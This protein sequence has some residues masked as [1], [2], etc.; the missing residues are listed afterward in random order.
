M[1]YGGGWKQEYKGERPAD[2]MWVVCKPNNGWSSPCN[3]VSI[4]ISDNWSFD[5]AI[6]EDGC[7]VWAYD[8]TIQGITAKNPAKLHWNKIGV[9]P[10]NIPPL[11]TVEKML[12]DNNVL[13]LDI[14]KFDAEG[15]E[16]D[17]LERM[18]F[19]T[20]TLKYRVRQISFEIHFW[21]DGCRKNEPE[22]CAKELRRWYNILKGLEDEGFVMYNTH[23]N[24]QSSRENL[25]QPGGQTMCCLELGAFNKALF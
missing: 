21:N 24:P 5:D 14:L 12:E 11:Q 16:W 15:A 1:I 13:I 6:V 9:G 20:H 10:K 18:I 23:V 4:G 3:V 19:Q 22:R 8:H 2:G 7:E 25:D 17:V